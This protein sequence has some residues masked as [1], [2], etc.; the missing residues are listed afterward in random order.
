MR[1]ASAVAAEQQATTASKA[2]TLKACAKLV[3]H[4]EL[5]AVT[6]ICSLAKSV[7]CYKRGVL[8]YEGLGNAPDV[9]LQRDSKC[10]LLLEN[11][12]QLP[13]LKS[14][15]SAAL[16]S[17]EALPD[18]PVDQEGKPAPYFGMKGINIATANLDD[19]VFADAWKLACLKKQEEMKQRSSLLQESLGQWLTTSWHDLCE[20]EE[21][22][23]V[24]ASFDRTIGKTKV[25]PLSESLEEFKKVGPWYN[26]IM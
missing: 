3:Q 25:K 10:S 8:K 21:L 7:S 4:P 24:L 5:T 19:Q 13:A 17:L 16:A 6:D 1:Q 14:A 26:S 22:P 9:R 20:S 2:V 18:I 11:L 23:E 12:G 15:E